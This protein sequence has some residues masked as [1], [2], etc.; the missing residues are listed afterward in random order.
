MISRYVVAVS[1]GVDSVV[2]LDMLS[3]RPNIELI[4]AHFDH[5]IRN[6]SNLDAVFVSNLAKKYDFPFETE[7][8]ELG[9]SASES[10]ARK[11]RYDF[12]KRVTKK[13]EAQLMTAHH[14]DDVIETIAIN[15][16]RGTGWRGL[17]SMDSDVI[18]PL[19]DM[20]KKEILEYA[21][22]N[23][24]SWREDSTNN[25]DRYLRNRIRQKLRAV[26]E[27][28]QRQLLGLW[29][30]QKTIKRQIN[31]L[32]NEICPINQ[33]YN[34]QFFISLDESVALELIRNITWSRLTRP[35]MKKVLVAIKTYLPSKKHYPGGGIKM[36]FSSR[37]FTVKLLK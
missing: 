14:S 10:D 30:Y 33:E 37:N 7:R 2:L 11:K 12:L 23:N 26:N 36:D 9:E 15:L 18:R 25:S 13:Y 28:E 32:I 35:Q 34:R 16:T 21:N 1:G 20:S 17:A 8:V 19:T 24:L 27:D 31:D 3:K 6:D 29:M 5:G 4:V 22:D